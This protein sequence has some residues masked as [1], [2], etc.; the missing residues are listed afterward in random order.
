MRTLF[1]EPLC[2]VQLLGTQRN[3]WVFVYQL[4]LAGSKDGYLLTYEPSGALQEAPGKGSPKRKEITSFCVECMG[5]EI[6]TLGT[7][8]AEG[9]QL[10]CGSLILVCLPPI[11]SI[12]ELSAVLYLAC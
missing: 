3:L 2:Y 10:E 8:S 4:A 12:T 11:F 9:S 6:E 7:D 5:A 1:R